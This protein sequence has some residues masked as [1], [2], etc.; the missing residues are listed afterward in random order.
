MTHWI[1]VNEPML[2]EHSD[3]GNEYGCCGAV[4]YVWGSGIWQTCHRGTITAGSSAKLG[5]CSRTK[6]MTIFRKCWHPH[7]PGK[8]LA[9]YFQC[10]KNGIR[11]NYKDIPRVNAREVKWDW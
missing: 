1:T 7:S 3:A 2:P 10:D 8:R 9:S 5:P 4:Q 6:Y 11:V